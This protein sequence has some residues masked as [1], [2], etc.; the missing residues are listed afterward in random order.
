MNL[1]N[2]ELFFERERER[3]MEKESWN[4]RDR[5]K[6]DDKK[7]TSK[8]IV[9]ATH[10]LSFLTVFPL[11]NASSIVFASRIWCSSHEVEVEVTVQRYCRMNLVVSVLP[12]PDSP[13]MIILWLW[14]ALFSLLYIASAI[15]KMCGSCA[16]SWHPCPW[17][18]NMYS[19]GSRAEEETD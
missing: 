19:C 18:L 11:P 10:L 15:A 6:R 2:R 4:V 3:E 9:R 13:E 8:Q 7:R 14:F 17:Y 12:A 16:V 1:P 5:I